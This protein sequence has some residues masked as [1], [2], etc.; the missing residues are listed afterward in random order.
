MSES[1]R[2]ACVRNLAAAVALAAAM[3]D[4]ASAWEMFPGGPVPVLIG[5]G[6]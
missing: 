2:R 1:N 6:R 4:P 5:R 3:A